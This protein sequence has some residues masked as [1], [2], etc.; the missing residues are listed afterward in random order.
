M[1][2]LEKLDALKARTGDNN[3]SLARNAGIPPTT[4]YG[5]YQKGYGNMKLSTL[6]AICDYFD[7]SLDYLAKDS[8]E[9]IRD[10]LSSNSPASKKLQEIREKLKS[11][12]ID[13]MVQAM[14]H[15]TLKE[16][17]KMI[18]MGKVLFPPRFTNTI[19]E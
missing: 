5:L 11:P 9:D 1:N 7:V 17:Q 16:Q 2:L 10:T 3:A 19:D 18:D 8:Y 4:I 15:M 6:Q 12:L 14:Q 13:E